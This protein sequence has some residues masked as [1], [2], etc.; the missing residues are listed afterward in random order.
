VSSLWLTLGLVAITLAALWLAVSLAKASA[1]ARS[2]L[3]DLE[4]ELEAVRRFNEEMRHPRKRG[5]DLVDS[6][7]SRSF[8]RVRDDR[9][10]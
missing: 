6:L 1:S 9:G 4:S 3:D 2:D 10:R 7:R 5:K 8:G